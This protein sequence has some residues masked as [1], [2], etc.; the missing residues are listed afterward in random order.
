VTL[1]PSPHIL[2]HV[3]IPQYDPS[4]AVHR[5]LAEFGER[6]RQLAA[7]GESGAAALRELESEMD[8]AAA[9]LWGL[10]NEGLAMIGEALR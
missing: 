1:H 10:G 5:S 2:R 3:A 8:S 4:I 6:A 9:T 7:T